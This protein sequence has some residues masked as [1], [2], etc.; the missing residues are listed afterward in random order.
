MIYA[1]LPSVVTRVAILVLKREANLLCTG[2]TRDLHY[3]ELFA[4]NTFRRIKNALLH[5]P[6]LQISGMLSRTATKTQDSSH[7]SQSYKR[8]LKPSTSKVRA[9]FALL[10]VN[11]SNQTGNTENSDAK[12]L[13]SL[14]DD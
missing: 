8:M 9:C 4:E 6:S 3:N 13:C 12:I 2:N 5:K 7:A 11:L 1:T 14:R 10:E